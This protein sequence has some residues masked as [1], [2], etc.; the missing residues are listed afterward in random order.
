MA[1]AAARADATDAGDRR[2]RPRPSQAPL[3]G[4][5]PGALALARN[6]SPALLW[7]AIFL[8]LR[9]KASA[10]AEYLAGWRAGK[11]RRQNERS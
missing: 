2:R 9:A 11:N 1:D 5:A 10:R 8:L 4:E 7:L 6:A 3:R